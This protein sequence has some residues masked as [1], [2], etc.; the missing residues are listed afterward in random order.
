MTNLSTIETQI[1]AEWGTVRAFFALH[2][3]ITHG[4]AIVAAYM[5]G[6]ILKGWPL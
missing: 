4:V 1:A 3:V 2:P 6:A 5:L